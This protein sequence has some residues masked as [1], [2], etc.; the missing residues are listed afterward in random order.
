[1]VLS[2]RALAGH[3]D[4]TDSHLSQPSKDI[5]PEFA[6]SFASGLLCGGLPPLNDR[7]ATENKDIRKLCYSANVP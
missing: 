6:T 5:D 1:M 2:T 4:N 3:R 7:D